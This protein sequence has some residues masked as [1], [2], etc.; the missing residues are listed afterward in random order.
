LDAKAGCGTCSGG[1]NRQRKQGDE[2]EPATLYLVKAYQ[3]LTRMS[4]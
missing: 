4:L 1:G 3:K 2:D